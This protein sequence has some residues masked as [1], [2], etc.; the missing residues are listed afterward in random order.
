M[1]VVAHGQGDAPDAPGTP[2]RTLG[3]RNHPVVWFLVRRVST[4]IGAL[5]VASILIYGAVLILP[6]NVA[7][8]VLGRNGTP[9]AVA[10]LNAQ[11]HLN[12]P[13]P[14]R[15]FDWAKGLLTGH[16]GNSMASLAQGGSLTVAH[17][18]AT[19]LRNSVILAGVTLAIFIPLVLILAIPAALNA[20]GKTDH[21]IS[22]TSLAIGSLPEFLLGTLLI[23][24][25]FSELNLLPAVSSI[26]PGSTP[27][28]NVKELV[29]PV[30]TLLGVSTA[31]GVRLLRASLVEV[32]REDYVAMARLNGIR[33]RRVI[34]RYALRNALGP[35]IQVIAQTAQYLIGGI[36][37]TESVFNYP[38]IGTTLVQSVSVR[39]PQM[40]S[41]I[42]M[43][44][45]IFYVGVNVIADL[46]VV[47]LVPK[48][49]T[50]L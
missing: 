27:F 2:H 34:W 50:R 33:E 21:G 40:V 23:A 10:A 48:L 28:S 19:P 37:I 5:F 20:G 1:A 26:N 49:R 17:A 24:I 13:V 14:E 12:R 43:L 32:I 4:G 29:L 3:L 41:V 47:L 22:L 31:F 38:G 39:D 15:Y 45:A 42:A 35:S 16:L 36:I 11:L 18:I 6:G 7:Q 8:V 9:K 44:L 30:L 46:A 25:F